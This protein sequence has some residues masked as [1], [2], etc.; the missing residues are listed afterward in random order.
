MDKTTI[1]RTVA[2]LALQRGRI[3]A[4]EECLQDDVWAFLKPRGSL[5]AVAAELGISTAYLC[6]IAHG[7]RKVSQTI[8]EKVLAL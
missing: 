7:R 4:L 2:Q 8:V 6:D 1:K 3:A 5:H